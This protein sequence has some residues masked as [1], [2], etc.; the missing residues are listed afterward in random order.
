MHITILLILLITM[1]LIQKNKENM[2][3]ELIMATSAFILFM[4]LIYII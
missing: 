3:D 2:D 4:L 1:I